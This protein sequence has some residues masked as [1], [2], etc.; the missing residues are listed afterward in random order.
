MKFMDLLANQFSYVTLLS[1]SKMGGS[2]FMHG[3]TLMIRWPLGK[4]ALS[5]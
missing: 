4:L 3:N 5:M 1:G 2:I